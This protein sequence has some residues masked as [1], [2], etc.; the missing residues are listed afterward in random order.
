MQD[1]TFVKEYNDNYTHMLRCG[2]LRRA[3]SNAGLVGLTIRKRMM[4]GTSYHD[5]KV[6]FLTILIVRW[7]SYYIYLI[8]YCSVK[9]R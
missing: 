7:W 6:A 4:M 5:Q 1:R 3:T 2:A 8:A 9:Y